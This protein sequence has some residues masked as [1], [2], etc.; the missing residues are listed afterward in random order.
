MHKRPGAAADS[1]PEDGMVN[2]SVRV[3][4]GPRRAWL[5]DVLIAAAILALVLLGAVACTGGGPSSVSPG[6][7]PAAGGSAAAPSAVGYSHCMRSHG[8]PNYPDP[9]S[10]GQVPKADPQQL[11]I[12]GAQL[13]A[14]QRS[15]RHQYPGN[16]GALGASLRQC[17]ETGNCPQAMVHRVMNSMLSFS[18]C[19][20][21]H[22]VL[23][24]PDP[25]VD[26]EGRP[27]FNLV[28]IH[29]T[30]WNSPQIQNKIYECEHVMPAGGGVPAIYPGGPG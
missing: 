15:C 21:A 18:R 27:G 3:L 17:E 8:V 12:S 26:S 10:G 14:A 13:Q 16:G 6:G 25:I 9:P 2:A 1:T 23:N 7:S 11:G 19:M 28:P 20:R 5:P 22:G 4:R 30:N 24:W 29:G